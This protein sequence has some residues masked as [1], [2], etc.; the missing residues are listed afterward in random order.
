M[1]EFV[2][3]DAFQFCFIKN[4]E[5]AGGRCDDGMFGVATG[6]KSVRRRIV[7]NINLRPRQTGGDG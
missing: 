3:D 1:G 2:G 7:N 6:G 5:Q 4:L